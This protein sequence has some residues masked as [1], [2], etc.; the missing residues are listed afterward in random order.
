MTFTPHIGS[1]Q[2]AAAAEAVLVVGKLA[3]RD[4]PRTHAW[5]FR[6]GGAR[7]WEAGLRMVSSCIAST[8]PLVP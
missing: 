2:P 5:V 7:V 6:L 1:P 3:T 4:I 8:P